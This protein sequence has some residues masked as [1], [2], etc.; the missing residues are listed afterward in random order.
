MTHA[1]PVPGP[2]HRATPR[3][4]RTRLIQRV[5]RVWREPVGRF[6][7]RFPVVTAVVFLVPAVFPAIERWLIQWTLHNLA[8]ARFVTAEPVLVAGTTITLGPTAIQIVPDCTPL[9]PALLLTGAILAFP[10]GWRVKLAGVAL[11]FAALWVYNLVRIVA[12][13][14]VLRHAPAQFDLVHVY[15]WQSVTLL[16]VL[17]GFV[18]WARFAV[19]S[20]SSA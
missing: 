14:A 1:K 2:G 17:G 20:P 19:P 8:L 6:L 18:L 9:F 11:G 4:H 10:A 7:L 3:L 15:L 13:F 16:V 5:R 12:L